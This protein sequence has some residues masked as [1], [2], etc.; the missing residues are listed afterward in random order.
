MDRQIDPFI[1][2][3][4]TGEE[5][6]AGSPR[7]R[8]IH[9]DHAQIV[10][11]DASWFTATRRIPT[12]GRYLE[13]TVVH[14][15]HPSTAGGMESDSTTLDHYHHQTMIRSECRYPTGIRK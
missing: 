4:S 14:P 7:V 8:S 13:S 5:I 11:K 15:S 6:E 3:K 1:G 9:G 2:G 10:R 12:I